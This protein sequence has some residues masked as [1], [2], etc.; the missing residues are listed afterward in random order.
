MKTKRLVGC[1]DS[2]MDNTISTR[3]F[4]VDTVSKEIKDVTLEL[5]KVI[6]DFNEV[7]REILQTETYSLV[8]PYEYKYGMAVYGFGCGLSHYLQEEEFKT[9]EARAKKKLSFP[10]SSCLISMYT[11]SD[12]LGI[13]ECK[14]GAFDGNIEKA[15]E[16]RFFAE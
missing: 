15:L 3:Y 10:L 6:D 1:I 8:I 4:Y 5:C 14:E 16:K 13:L 2:I 11:P 9:L 12:V 7:S